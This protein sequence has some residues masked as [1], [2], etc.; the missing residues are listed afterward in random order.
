M[1]YEKEKKHDHLFTEWENKFITNLNKDKEINKTENPN[2]EILFRKKNHKWELKKQIPNG[3]KRFP[4][5]EPF[6]IDIDY[7]GFTDL[8]K[9]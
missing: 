5:R 1:N 6:I 3:N 8:L 2:K 4:K 9:I 7:E